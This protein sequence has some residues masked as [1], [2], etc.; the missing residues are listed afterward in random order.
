MRYYVKSVFFTVFVLLTFPVNA[1]DE[2]SIAGSINKFGQGIG[3]LNRSIKEMNQGLKSTRKEVAA[4]GGACTQQTLDR[5]QRLLYEYDMYRLIIWQTKVALFVNKEN[6]QNE[7]PRYCTNEYMR[8]SSCYDGAAFFRQ[9]AQAAIGIIPGCKD[10]YEQ[11]VAECRNPLDMFVNGY[12]MNDVVSGQS[13][14]LDYYGKLAASIDSTVFDASGGILEIV[15]PISTKTILHIKNMFPTEAAYVDYSSLKQYIS[16]HKGGHKIL[17]CL[18]PQQKEIWYWYKN[19]WCNSS[20]YS[21]CCRWCW[22]TNK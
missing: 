5:Y 2:G 15:T 11:Y 3:G 18:Y 10:R 12:P 6:M 19:A 4:C 22:R 17:R 16:A 13:P 9:Q 7:T 8:W 21:L 1:F 14:Y 20:Y